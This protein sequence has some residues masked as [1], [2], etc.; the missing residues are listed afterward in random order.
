MADRL[1][2]VARQRHVDAVPGEP[3]VE[4]DA[5]SSAVR[6]SSSSS[7]ATRTSFAALPIGPRSSG[8]SSPI[9]R[10]VAGQLGLAAEVAHAQLLELGRAAG[11]ADRG[12]GLARS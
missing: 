12:L 11:V 10:S 8:G 3:P 7:S 6:S 9:E 5:S 4:L 1:R 2:R